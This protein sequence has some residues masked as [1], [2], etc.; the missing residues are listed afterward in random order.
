MRWRATRRCSA[1]ELKDTGKK[2]SG[3]LGDGIKVVAQELKPADLVVGR[4]ELQI[5]F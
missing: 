1:G 4:M 5:V 2:G 3:M